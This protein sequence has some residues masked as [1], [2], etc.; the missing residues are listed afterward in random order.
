LTLD[1]LKAG[2]TGEGKAVARSVVVIQINF[3]G[4]SL[5]VRFEMNIVRIMTQ[6]GEAG[7]PRLIEEKKITSPSLGS[8]CDP[9]MVR[10]TIRQ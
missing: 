6:G 8:V 9:Q 5:K 3:C 1:T 4:F 10:M 2:S 7:V